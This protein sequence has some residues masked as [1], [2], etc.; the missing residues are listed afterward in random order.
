MPVASWGISDLKEI[1][2][3]QN[4]ACRYFLEGGKCA[5]N[6]AMRGDMG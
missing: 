2:S 3:V 6:L 5:S 1:K 4:K